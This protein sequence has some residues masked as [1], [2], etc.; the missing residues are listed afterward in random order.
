MIATAFAVALLAAAGQAPDAAKPADDGDKVICKRFAETGSFV[1]KRR[2]C[3]TKDE[4]TKLNDLGQD[5]A[6]RWVEEN[7]SR[8]SGGS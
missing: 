8:P 1:K 7:R 6:E 5:A 3:H 4:W 2:V